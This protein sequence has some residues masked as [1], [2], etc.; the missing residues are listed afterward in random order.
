MWKGDLVETDGRSLLDIATKAGYEQVANLLKSGQLPSIHMTDLE[1]SFL[2]AVEC[3]DLDQIKA[4]FEAGLSP[5]ARISGRSL[6]NWL[7]EMYSRSD[8]FPDCLRLLLHRGVR[9]D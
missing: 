7:T 8:R 1:P 3:H 5:Q 4:A 6:V 2:N 9:L